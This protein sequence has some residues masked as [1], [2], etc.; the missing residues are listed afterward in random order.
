MRATEPVTA[1][2]VKATDSELLIV[3]ADRE[4]RIPWERCSARLAKATPRQR[5]EAALSPGGYGIHWPLIDEDLSIR[6][7]LR[8]W[9]GRS[10]R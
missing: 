8:D 6:G 4:I 5:R 2:S 1:K 9:E 3:L 10:D 7:L